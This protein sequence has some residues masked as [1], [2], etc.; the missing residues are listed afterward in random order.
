MLNMQKY[1]LPYPGVGEKHLSYGKDN[2]IKMA[3]SS[4]KYESIMKQ[5]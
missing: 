5:R 2:A 1:F 4:K 3:L